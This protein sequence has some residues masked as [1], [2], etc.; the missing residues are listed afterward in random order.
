MNIVRSRG[1]QLNNEKNKIKVGKFLK[2]RGCGGKKSF[3][4]E[5]FFPPRE[6]SY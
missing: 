2:V 6:K 4:Q 3:F 5:V 1:E